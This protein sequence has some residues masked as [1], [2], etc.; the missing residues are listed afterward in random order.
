ML[1]T[2]FAI[3]KQFFLDL[4]GY[5]PGMEI[6]GGEEM[7]LSF[8]TWMC[9]GSM[10]VI[11]CSSVAHLFRLAKHR[12]FPFHLTNI[13]RVAHVWMDDY[14]HE[15]FE[16]YGDVCN[17]RDVGNITDRL[18]IKEKLQ[19]K[20]FQWYMKNIAYMADVPK[21]VIAQG[22]IH[23]QGKPEQCLCAAVGG[24]SDPENL[25]VKTRQCQR[26]GYEEFWMIT[27]SGLLRRDSRCVLYS[28]TTKKLTHVEC[29]DTNQHMKW[30]FT[31]NNT[32]VHELSGKCLSL[33]NDL[34]M[35]EC[36]QGEELQQWKLVRRPKAPPIR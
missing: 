1:G 16:R 5:D 9:G 19:C 28:A 20:N 27:K 17:D 14:K 32:L 36:S 24:W 26:R 3:D 31:M 4:G 10:W 29:N 21:D 11:P 34:T 22:E 15:V 2:E 35:E 13:L 25:K 6:W 7:E 18:K 30:N 12:S 8:K 33:R 23:N